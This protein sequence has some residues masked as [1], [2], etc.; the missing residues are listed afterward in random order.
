MVSGQSATHAM[1]RMVWFDF[2]VYHAKTLSSPRAFGFFA[3]VILLT[4]EIT[5][6]AEFTIALIHKSQAYLFL[7]SFPRKVGIHEFC[8]P[9]WIALKFHCMPGFSLRYVRNDTYL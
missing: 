9:S 8:G 4:A 5:E 2:K 3:I 1:Q 7:V 6:T